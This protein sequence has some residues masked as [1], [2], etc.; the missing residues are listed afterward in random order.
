MA[1]CQGNAQNNSETKQEPSH[2]NNFTNIFKFCVRKISSV[3][4]SQLINFFLSFVVLWLP[5]TTELKNPA[6]MEFYCCIFYW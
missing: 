1:T 5:Q 6:I 3:L 4:R 2:F